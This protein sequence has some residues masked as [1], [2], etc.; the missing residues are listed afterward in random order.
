M[1]RGEACSGVG[2]ER[3]RNRKPSLGQSAHSGPV[4][5]ALLSP[6]TEC[7][8]PESYHPITKYT[9]SARVSRDRVVVEVTLYDR[10]EPFPRLRRRIVHTRSQLLLDFFQLGCH[11]LG[12]RFALEGEFLILSLPADMREAQEAERFGLAFSSL[13]PV[14]FG[15]PPELDPARLIWMQFQSKLLQPFRE[16]FPEAVCIGLI[17]KTQDD[18]VRVPY[19]HHL[20]LCPFLAP[21]VHPKVE[22]VVQVNVCK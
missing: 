10:L 7:P 8:A 15:K 12:D 3:T 16:M 19:D 20:A 14:W 1:M 2:M 17:L 4:G 22:S 18:V 6:A 5:P 21:D 11:A 13:F 9:E